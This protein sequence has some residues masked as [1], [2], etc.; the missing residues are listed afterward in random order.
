MM[1]YCSELPP[2]ALG[3]NPPDSEILDGEL[4]DALTALAFWHAAVLWKVRSVPGRRRTELEELLVAGKIQHRRASEAVHR[5]RSLKKRRRLGSI[6]NSLAAR[7]SPQ[8]HENERSVHSSR[9]LEIAGTF[10]GAALAKDGLVTFKAVDVRVDEL[11]GRS[12]PTFSELR[13]AVVQE[14]ARFRRET[15][16]T[17]G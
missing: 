10:V 14:L 7:P 11:D 1:Q 17:C 3:T 8:D 15:E 9:V 16:Q 5:L 13:N 4:S 12:W 2:S 6:G